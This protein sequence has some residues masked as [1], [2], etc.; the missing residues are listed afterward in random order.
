MAK[1]LDHAFFRRVKSGENPG[2]PRFQSFGRYHSF[3]DPQGGYAI[4]DGRIHLSKIGDVKVTLRHPIEG[5]INTCTL[6]A[7]NGH[8]GAVFSCEVEA[9]P[10]VPP[11]AMMGG[12]LGIHHLLVTSDGAC[13]DHPQSL[14][15][16]ECTLK[17]LQ[18]A[19]LESTRGVEAE[20][21]GAA[22]GQSP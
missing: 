20:A 13:F 19:C 8:Y 18:R 17:R 7:K 3:T 16:A 14:W 11:P 15:K 1:R 4:R 12:D 6:V 9:V 5:R 2:Y 22:T 10:M 21:S